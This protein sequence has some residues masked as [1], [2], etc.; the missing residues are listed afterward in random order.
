MVK[1]LGTAAYHAGRGTDSTDYQSK[2][3]T[4]SLPMRPVKPF[5]RLGEYEPDQNN[6]MNILSRKERYRISRG[7]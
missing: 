5:Q 3:G 2:P 6:F 1:T 7:V 4:Q